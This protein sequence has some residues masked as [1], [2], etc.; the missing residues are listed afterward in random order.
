MSVVPMAH[1]KNEREALAM[2][3]MLLA[4]ASA[5]R[6][7]GGSDPISTTYLPQFP[8][9]A[10]PQPLPA[11]GQRRSPLLQGTSNLSPTAVPFAPQQ[12]QLTVNPT[13]PPSIAPSPQ[14]PHIEEHQISYYT[15][16]E[17][18]RSVNKGLMRRRDHNRLLNI[19]N[20]G[21]IFSPKARDLIADDPKTWTPLLTPGV[22]SF[23][24]DPNNEYLVGGNTRAHTATKE[25]M[26][27]SIFNIPAERADRDLMIKFF[28]AL[29]SNKEGDVA[30]G[31]SEEDEDDGEEGSAPDGE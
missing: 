7:A 6:A 19:I 31:D 23:A 30:E 3:D 2:R 12:H 9:M 4:A 11:S 14:V 5:A 1:M 29:L 15:S 18:F 24:F 25:E 27:D 13:H 16:F 21:L 26:Y 17:H 8:P 28:N 20:Y 22:V 10:G